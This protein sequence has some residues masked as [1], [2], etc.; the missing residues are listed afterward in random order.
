M[1]TLRTGWKRVRTAIAVAGLLLLDMPIGVASSASTPT[2]AAA[3]QA[4]AERIHRHFNQFRRVSDTHLW[5]RSDYWATPLESLRAGGGDC[6]D[7]AAIK[8]FA[9]RELGVPAARLR[10]VH[11]RL[12]DLRSRQIQAHVVLLY[13]AERGAAWL[14]LDNLQDTVLPLWQ[15]R[16]LLPVLTFNENLLARWDAN[17]TE[18]LLGSPELLQSWRQLLLRHRVSDS[19]AMVIYLHNL[20]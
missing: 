9:L 20:L 7:I 12:I 4:R 11:G 18:R 10:L 3:E 2:A 6:E 14:V 17:G 1:R 8:Y 5:G 16:D 19:V 13:R 15:R